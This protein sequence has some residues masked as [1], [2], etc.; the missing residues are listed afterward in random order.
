MLASH[1]LKASLS[2]RPLPEFV[3]SSVG[4][5]VN[6]N[7]VSVSVPS[8]IQDGDLIIAVGVHD[9]VTTS[10]TQPTG[11]SQIWF[12]NA[13]A[14]TLFL[15]VKVAASESGSYTWTWGNTSYSSVLVL[16]YRNATRINTVGAITRAT[17]ATGTAAGISPT[18]AGVLCAVFANETDADITTPPAGMTL[19]AYKELFWPPRFA[20]YDETNGSGSKSLV[21]SAS[22]SVASFQFQITNE[23]DIAPEFVASASTQNTTSSTTLTI[24]KP[25]GTIEGDL[26]VAVMAASTATTWTG[27]TGW[28]ELADQGAGPSL[29]I[30]YRVAGPSEP[31]SYVFT[32]ADSNTGS[33]SILTY[34][35]A[36]YDTIAGSFT[37]GTNPLLLASIT[38]T[39]SQCIL[40][41]AAARRQSGITLGTPP[42]M[43][44]RVTDND[45][46]TPSYIV[47]DQ[48]VPKGPTGTRSV[49]TG[50]GTNVAGIMLTLKPTRSL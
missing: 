42:G 29:R 19:R 13:T 33:G 38:P 40:I 22:N 49:S 46:T 24:A 10:V 28:T 48:P 34:R 6:S 18:F 4:E 2:A 3:S 11:F 8:G 17:S 39:E 44:A 35:Y 14:N 50:S 43:V 45:A 21:W 32:S 20:A 23:P 15:A 37:T 9:V 30:A 41:A 16:V 7:T 25:T 26:M 12:D 31:S 47:L 36:A 5:G 27:D 1:L